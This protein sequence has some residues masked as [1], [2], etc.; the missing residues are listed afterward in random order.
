MAS[1][2]HME[3]NASRNTEAKAPNGLSGLN[4]S[5]AEADEALAIHAK[6][7]AERA[8]RY[9]P[10]EALAQFVDVT[11]LE[12]PRLRSFARDPWLTPRSEQTC[13]QDG[14]RIKF[15]NL[16]AGFG[17]LLTG[18]KLVKN[19]GIDPS[20]VY[21][22]DA[23]G[24]WGGTWYWNRYPGLMCDLISYC[25]LPLLEE[26]GY[27]PKHHYS[28]GTEI[29]EY[30]NMLVHKYGLDAE[31]MFRTRMESA[32]WNDAEKVWVVKLRKERADGQP[33]LVLTVRTQFLTLSNGVL[34]YPQL[35]NKEGLSEYKGHV[36]HTSRWD[37]DYTGGSPSEPRLVGL[38]GKRVGIIGTGATAVQAVPVLARHAK[39]LYVFQRTPSAINR[40]D[41]SP[42]DQSWWQIATQKPRWQHEFNTSLNDYISGRSSEPGDPVILDFWTRFTTYRTLVGGEAVARD[43]IASY[44]AKL[45]IEDLQHTKPHR[46]RVDEVIQDATTA[47]SLKAWYPTWCKRPCFHD[48]YLP[49]FN[50]HHVHLIDTDGKGIERFTERGIIANGT[51]YPL[52]LIIMSTG[53]R[54]KPNAW[55]GGR[56]NIDLR[57]RNGVS[58]DER[59]TSEGAAT[60]HGLMSHD[61][62]N[63][64]FN[65]TPFQCGATAN[66]A[67]VMD[68]KTDHIAYIVSEARK[69]AGGDGKL[70]IEPTVEAQEA[71][72]QQ[73]LMRASAFAGMGG[74]TPGYLN[75]E[76]VNDGMETE[77]KMVSSLARCLQWLRV[78]YVLTLSTD[79]RGQGPRRGVVA[80]RSTS[81]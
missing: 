61:F 40:R 45:H 44:L 52:D 16:G 58:L 75:G 20:D 77:Q 35:P 80:W 64:F 74:C 9:R 7:A 69:K 11:Q 48:D 34:N 81:A 53:F 56:A 30:I 21:T 43:Q 72:T 73:I 42:T 51:E 13:L 68:R 78:D 17:G 4:S 41:Q 27:M 49:T 47:A 8:K 25:Y 2:Q 57:G 63:L 62:P 55:H 14:N 32:H 29:R 38:E 71:W 50:Q 12:D 33:D 28:Y 5:P 31:A 26:A 6:Y 15:L 23:A 37:Y 36:F 18:I 59:W 10:R 66:L 39:Q 1:L 60:L 67:H 24:G 54:M 19:A 46:D 3:A 79:R 70:T 22:I 65:S 76:G